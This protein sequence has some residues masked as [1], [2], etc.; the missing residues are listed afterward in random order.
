M[1]GQWMRHLLEPEFQKTYWAG[2]GHGGLLVAVGALAFAVLYLIFRRGANDVKAQRILILAVLVGAIFY[3]KRDH[4][5]PPTAQPQPTAQPHRRPLIRPTPAPCPGPDPCP[6]PR[7]PRRPWGPGETAPVG[8]NVFGARP[9]EGGKVSPDGTEEITCD[10][11]QSEK[12][13]NVGGRDGSGLCVFTSV[14]YDARFQNVRELFDFQQKMRSELGGGWPEKVDRMMKKYAP[15][16][17][18]LQHTGGDPEILKAAMRGGRGVCVTYN[19]H[20]CHYSGSIAHMVWLPHFSEKW[21]CVSD[22]NFVR[23]D[24]Y[25]WMSPDEFLKRWRG[26]GGGWAIILLAPPP[27]P[28]PKNSN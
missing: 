8:A 17:K 23:D 26:T 12:K 20:D 28:P 15:T 21:A 16:V 10:L 2:F 9:V 11:P 5:P 14:E 18:Y 27:P 25:V 3:A 7:P 4:R 1:L 22:N 19:G 24:Q 6:A 13:K